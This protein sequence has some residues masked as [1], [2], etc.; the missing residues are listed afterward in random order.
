VTYV[1]DK[2]LL[3]LKE[4][5]RGSGLSPEKFATDWKVLHR[6]ISAW[7]SS[8]D[9]ETV[10]L[11]VFNPANSIL[12][13]R[14]DFDIVYGASGDG[15]MWVNAD[16]IR[17]HIRKAGQWPSTCDYRIVVTTKRGRPDVEGWSATT[18]RSTE[19]F[20]RQSLGTTIDGNGLRSG[21]SYWRQ[22]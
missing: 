7:L 18:L 8:R 22:L 10:I 19:G 3:S 9:L 11:E 16:D 21:A 17:Y 14:W 5:I 13:G 6:G 15:S 2:M 12:I 1:A 20:I 4:I